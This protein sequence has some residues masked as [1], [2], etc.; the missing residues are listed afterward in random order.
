[1][2]DYLTA[3]TK[4]EKRPPVSSRHGDR[5]A[6]RNQDR[7]HDGRDAD[8]KRDRKQRP[9][10]FL[11]QLYYDKLARPYQIAEEQENPVAQ[12]CQPLVCIHVITQVPSRK[13]RA[14]HGGQKPT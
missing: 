7:Q 10:L 5:A 9:H 11:H 8:G 6:P 4:K 12:F 13:L 1:L 2:C 3:N 14:R